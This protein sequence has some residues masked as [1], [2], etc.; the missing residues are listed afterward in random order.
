MGK[1][2]NTRFQ[3]LADES[4]IIS[5]LSRFAKWIY[6]LL[7][8]GLFGRLFSAYSIENDLFEKRVFS[9]VLHDAGRADANKQ[10]KRMFSRAVERSRVLGIPER[11]HEAMQQASFS[12]HGMFWLLFGTISLLCYYLQ[13]KMSGAAN[14]SNA[15]VGGIA[16]VFSIPM[17]AVNVPFKKVLQK[18]V[19]F[20][21]IARPLGIRFST[22]DEESNEK[23][24][25]IAVILAMF[26]GAATY[27]VS[28][29]RFLAIVVLLYVSV[30]LV[31]RPEWGVC[32][33]AA[34][35]PWTWVFR[36][37]VIIVLIPSILSL[38]GFLGKWVRGRRAFRWELMDA[39]VGALALLS[40]LYTIVSCKNAQALQAGL[41]TVLSLTLYFLIVNLFRVRE[42]LLRLKRIL[43]FSAALTGVYHFIAAFTGMAEVG[44]VPAS[45]DWVSG[46]GTC[47]VVLVLLTLSEFM[48]ASSAGGRLYYGGI[49]AALILGLCTTGSVL[50][51]Q[52]LIFGV[53]LYLLLYSAKMLETLIV[54]TL[55]L[56]AV[57]VW[58]RALVYDDSVGQW[59]GLKMRLSSQHA[60]MSRVLDYREG[61][62]DGVFSML[63]RYWFCGIGMGQ[64]SFAEIYPQFAEQGMA[65]R[66]RLTIR[67]CKP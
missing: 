60:A 12:A 52:L 21:W 8:T 66:S 53:C 62:R 27:W 6:R 7:T 48:N 47:F 9:S 54:F 38:L 58:I 16:F 36:F 56:T 50:T 65:G 11:L 3:R 63:Q 61:V 67:I 34:L 19:F 39:A 32:L 59:D 23:Y 22:D 37:D 33:S 20:S 14:V 10:R 2:N 17:L 30:T 41:Q 31:K 25:L 43:L 1:N 64:S 15:V 45:G 51:W 49:G 40:L 46:V 35:L 5:A 26:A 57:V 13:S 4:V 24:H 42:W 28:A 44:M 29:L 55:P 18:S